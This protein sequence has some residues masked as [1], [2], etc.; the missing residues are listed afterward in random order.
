MK[1]SVEQAAAEGVQYQKV[2]D[3]PAI[4][5]MDFHE[6]AIMSRLLF[7]EESESILEDYETVK[8][9]SIS[10]VDLI[11]QRTAAGKAG[12]QAQAGAAVEGEA[13]KAD[14]GAAVEG[15]AAKADAGAAVKE[16]AAKADA[17]AAV[18]EEAAKAEATQGKAVKGA[19]GAVAEGETAGKV[20]PKTKEE[21]QLEA[22]KQ[23]EEQGNFMRQRWRR[24]VQ[25]MHHA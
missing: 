4:R 8:P 17:G 2:N 16:E 5:L 6:L 11:A 18:K 13:A 20:E 14:A 12:V 1:P 7:P 22:K 9:D 21:L 25:F 10:E 3:S 24:E 15:E 23:A 19:S